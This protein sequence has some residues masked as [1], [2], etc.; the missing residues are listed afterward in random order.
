MIKLQRLAGG[1]KWKGIELICKS[2]KSSSP[3]CLDVAVERRALS[4]NPSYVSKCL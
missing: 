4:R 2:S 1:G 3:R